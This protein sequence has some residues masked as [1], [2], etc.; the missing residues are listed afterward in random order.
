MFLCVRQREIYREIEI[1]K[2]ESECY[3]S[4]ESVGEEAT[5]KERK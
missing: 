5:E 1:K 3:K 2:K 4:G